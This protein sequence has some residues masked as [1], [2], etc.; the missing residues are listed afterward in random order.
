[1]M[2][3]CFVGAGSIG[4][5]HIKNFAQICAE[6]HTKITIHLYRVANKPLEEDV[7]KH[8]Q[9]TILREDELDEKYDA[10]FITNPTYKHYETL[11]LFLNK[12]DVFFVEK[13]VFNTV[14]I[15]ISKFMKPGKKY[16]VACP[17]RYTNVL[18]DAKRVIEQENVFSVRAISSS[19]LPDWRKGVDYRETYSAHKDQGGGVK[20][21]LIHEWD[22]LYSMF[23]KPQKIFS[24]SG[25]YSQLE[26]DSEDLAVYIAQYENML[27]ELHLDYFG[28][29]VR[30]NLEIR[31]SKHEYIFD[32]AESKIYQD[33]VLRCEYIE[34]G[35]DKYVREMNYFYQLLCGSEASTNDLKKALETMKI[36]NEVYEGD[37][38]VR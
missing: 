24:L 6:N 19:Y 32:I 34:D 17:L 4:K 3:V 9:K 22:Y 16:Y 29:K 37:Y 8:V 5:R 20:I 13:P 35:N 28:R 38:Y 23:G 12:T 36:A 1:M 18:L 33:G 25:K 27:I 7:A 30:R 21:D 15:D 11:E 14:N 2:K 31:T 10:V 26:I